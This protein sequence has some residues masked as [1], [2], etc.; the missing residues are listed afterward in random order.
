MGSV[1]G[2]FDCYLANRGVKTLA[3]RMQKHQVNAFAVAKYLE[4]SPYVEKVIYPGK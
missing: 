4:S 1:P 3:I 2:P